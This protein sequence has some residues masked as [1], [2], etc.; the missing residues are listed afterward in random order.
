MVIVAAVRDDASL[1][2]RLY[3][4]KA[5][6]PEHVE[7]DREIGGRRRPEQLETDAS[8]QVQ[9]GR[10]GVVVPEGLE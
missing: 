4:Q 10:I 2:V 6:Q 8:E 7:C 3:T 1:R 5:Q 9:Q